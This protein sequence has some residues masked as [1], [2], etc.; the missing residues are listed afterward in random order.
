MEWNVWVVV[1]FLE[2]RKKKR[3]NEMLEAHDEEG[4]RGG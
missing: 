3:R 4:K 2:E 1:S